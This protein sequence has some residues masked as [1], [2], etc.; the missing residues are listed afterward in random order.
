MSS[1][2]LPPP[3]PRHDDADDGAALEPVELFQTVAVCMCPKKEWS[4]RVTLS[5]YDLLRPDGRREITMVEAR[6]QIAPA[7]RPLCSSY[8]ETVHHLKLPDGAQDEYPQADPC[9]VISPDRRNLACLLFHPHR[10][11]S[12]IVIFQL[13]KPRTDNITNNLPLP[14]YVS[15]SA[16]KERIAPMLAT[17]PRFVSAWGVT[18]ICNIPNVSPPLLLCGCMD[19]HL[20]WIDYRSAL[21]IATGD[22]GH[23]EAVRDLEVSATC[24]DRGTIVAIHPNGVATIASWKMEK[25]SQLTLLR[26]SSNPGTNI[27]QIPDSPSSHYSEVS[28]IPGGTKNNANTASDV[29]AS[30]FHKLRFGPTTIK[31]PPLH[32][33]RKVKSRES[34]DRFVLSRIRRK[35]GMTFRRVVSKRKLMRGFRRRSQGGNRDDTKRHMDISVIAEVEDVYAA[36]IL[37]SASSNLVAVLYRPGNVKTVRGNPCAVEVFGILSDHALKSVG[38]LELAPERVYELGLAT[39]APSWQEYDEGE[40]DGDEDTI[41]E[42]SVQTSQVLKSNKYGLM[43]DENSGCLAVS[44][45]YYVSPHDFN[46]QS[47]ACVWNWRI[48]TIGHSMASSSDSLHSR[49]Y[50]AHSELGP[51]LVHIEVNTGKQ[52]TLKKQIFKLGILSPPPSTEGSQITESCSVLLSGKSVS[53]P[54]CSQVSRCKF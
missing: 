11:S 20:I 22:L 6:V 8:R 31:A 43:Y 45:M 19:G 47:F 17:N 23:G 49:L 38:Q 26:H 48:N 13:R 42:L 15:E 50:F 9:A 41:S 14:S 46:M 37:G 52:I 40:G 24:L 35:H 10:Q 16:R 28:P 1:Q 2:Q 51:H 21:S 18:T 27:A 39:T 12:A 36:S 29:A 54:L 44:T 5:Y 33:K 34:M 25:S 53:F 7:C 4:V 3:N 30:L 32:A